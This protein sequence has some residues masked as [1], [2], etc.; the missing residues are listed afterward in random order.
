MNESRVLGLRFVDFPWARD[1]IEV[2]H[3]EGPRAQIV[4][5]IRL[6]HLR[7]ERPDAIER[8]ALGIDEWFTELA[9]H[10]QE[11]VTVLVADAQCDRD[12][13]YAADDRRPESVDELLVVTQEQNELVAALGANPLQVI[14]DAEGAL[15]QLPVGNLA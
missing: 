12:R 9:R 4:V 1:V 2:I 11:F 3:Q 7:G 8:A 13:H 5:Q 10:P 14:Q 15:V 6:A